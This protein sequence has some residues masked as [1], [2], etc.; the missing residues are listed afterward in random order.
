M[1]RSPFEVARPAHRPQ[2][3]WSVLAAIFVGGCGGGAARY[4]LDEAWPAGAGGFPW[5][6]FSI[7]TAGAFVLSLVVVLAAHVLPSRY[8]R[9]LLGTGFC[10]AFTTFSSIVVTVDE[11]LAHHHPGMAGGYLAASIGTGLL[12]AWLGLVAG[13]AV[14]A[15]RRSG[16]GER[17]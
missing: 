7:N 3:R 1:T 2:P 15:I 6:I 5:T 4:A 11:L 16:G 12:A 8:L 13:R 9:P 10:G 17:S 14:A